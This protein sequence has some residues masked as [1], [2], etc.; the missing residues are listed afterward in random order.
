[1]ISHASHAGMKVSRYLN[2][3]ISMKSAA[4]P[5]R[6]IPSAKSTAPVMVI[7]RIFRMRRFSAATCVLVYSLRATFNSLKNWLIASLSDNYNIPPTEIPGKTHVNYVV[8]FTRF[9][10]EPL[11]RV[12]DCQQ[13]VTA[14]CPALQRKRRNY[15][16]LFISSLNVSSSIFLF[17]PISS[18][19]RLTCLT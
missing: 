15:G 17:M 2:E 4:D 8:R 12:C 13:T 6:E 10:A 19:K 3:P 9:T 18:A 14:H 7:I 1:M 16:V 11:L 5:A